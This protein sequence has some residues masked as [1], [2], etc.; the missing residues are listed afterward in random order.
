M[1]RHLEIRRTLPAFSVQRPTGATRS[2]DW[3]WEEVREELDLWTRSQNRLLKE[4]TNRNSLFAD[5]GC[6]YTR[7]EI[8]ALLAQNGGKG[9]AGKRGPRW[10]GR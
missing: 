7:A 8:D 2:R 1:N 10:Q 9:G 4:E 6:F 3:S 5:S